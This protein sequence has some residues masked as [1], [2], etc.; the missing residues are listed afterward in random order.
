MLNVLVWTDGLNVSKCMRF[1]TK[2]LKF[3]KLYWLLK[4]S[5]TDV[6][7]KN[8][9]INLHRF[10]DAQNFKSTPAEAYHLFSSY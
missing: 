6:N 4:L 10:S 3:L 1:Q 8:Y 2:T 7:K 9:K 5:P